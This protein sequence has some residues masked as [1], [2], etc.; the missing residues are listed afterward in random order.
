MLIL[1]SV[2]APFGPPPPRADAR[3]G[4]L[5]GGEV[6]TRVDLDA[7]PSDGIPVVIFGIVGP[8]QG[9]PDIEARLLDGVQVD[10]RRADIFVAHHVLERPDVTAAAQCLRGE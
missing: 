8:V 7:W 3:R 10:H 1:E 4:P 9:A 2:R 5:L 6:P